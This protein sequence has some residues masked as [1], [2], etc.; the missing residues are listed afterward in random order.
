VEIGAPGKKPIAL[1]SPL[2]MGKHFHVP[3]NK[4]SDTAESNTGEHGGA[5]KSSAPRHQPSSSLP[6]CSLP[7][8]VWKCI[9]ST[10]RGR[11]HHFGLG[12]NRRPAILCRQRAQR[13]HPS[14]QRIAGLRAESSSVAEMM[15]KARRAKF[16]IPSSHSTVDPGITRRIGTNSP[17]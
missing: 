7:R 6:I 15:T 14:R 2:G 8:T 17:Q 3:G 11:G 13:P 12:S 1:Y 9:I 16:A 10:P 4:L 5:A